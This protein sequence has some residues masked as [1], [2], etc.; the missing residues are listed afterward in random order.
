MYTTNM[1]EGVSTKLRIYFIFKLIVHVQQFMRVFQIASV[2]W[3]PEKSDSLDL[4]SI[5]GL[6]D[7]S[8]G[9]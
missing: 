6:I 8:P 2:C 9:N 4:E 3:C 5:G 7:R 1:L